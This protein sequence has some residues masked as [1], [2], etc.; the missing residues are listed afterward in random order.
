MADAGCIF[1][2]GTGTT[3]DMKP[4][5][6]AG[7]GEVQKINPNKVPNAYKDISEFDSSFL[8]GFVSQAYKDFMQNIYGDMKTSCKLDRNLLIC[9][10][11]NSG[12]TILA[13]SVYNNLDNRGVRHLPLMDL[14]EVRDLMH[15]Y[16]KDKELLLLLEKSPIVFVILPADVP[17]RFVDTMSMIIQRRVRTGGGTIFLY[18]GTSKSL[19]NIDTYGKLSLLKGDGSYSSLGVYSYTRTDITED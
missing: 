6:C 12:K 19:S 7:S 3:A 9:S 5:T 18:G 11:P 1:C 10:P 15:G 14:L 4:C 2:G 17:T 16:S 8:P 13:Y